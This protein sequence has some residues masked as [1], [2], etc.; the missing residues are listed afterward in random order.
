MR[1]AQTWVR[2]ALKG[3][4]GMSCWNKTP[5][6]EFDMIGD[7]IFATDLRGF[8]THNFQDVFLLLSTH[9]QIILL[10]FWSLF[11]LICFQSPSFLISFFF[12]L[13][14]FSSLF[15]S[16][17]ICCISFGISLFETVSVSIFILRL[18]YLHLSEYLIP[19][20]SSLCQT[21]SSQ[22]IPSPFLGLYL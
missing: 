5:V 19:F 18:I 15:I 17:Y 6:I 7:R 13:L 21:F 2:T 10:I 8:D 1:D 11:Q 9:V 16:F 20:S 22:C 4:E 14:F 3:P 12:F